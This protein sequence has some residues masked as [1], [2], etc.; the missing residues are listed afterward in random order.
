MY[1]LCIYTYII[2]IYIYIYIDR[3]INRYRYRYIDIY[4]IIVIITLFVKQ[5]TFAI[6]TGYIR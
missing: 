5:Q 3:Q 4:K 1:D 6:D 2:Y